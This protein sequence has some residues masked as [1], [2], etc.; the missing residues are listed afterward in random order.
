V[1][2]AGRVRDVL[3]L[4]VGEAEVFAFDLPERRARR[5]R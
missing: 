5:G 1:L 3:E 2:D 4:Q